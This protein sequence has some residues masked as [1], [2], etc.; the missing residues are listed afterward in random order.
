MQRTTTSTLVLAALIFL[1]S[2]NRARATIGLSGAVLVNTPVYTIVIGVP[3]LSAGGLFISP[4]GKGHAST[5]LTIWTRD[6]LTSLEESEML[7]F[8]TSSGGVV[9]LSIQGVNARSECDVE[10]YSGGTTTVRNSG[11]PGFLVILESDDA[12]SV[13]LGTGSRNALSSGIPTS[14]ELGGEWGWLPFG[15]ENLKGSL[16]GADTLAKKKTVERDAG[17]PSASILTG[18]QIPHG[19]RQNDLLLS[20]VVN[21]A[22]GNVQIAN[23]LDHKGTITLAITV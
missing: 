10:I 15:E 11:V 2:E 4:Q 21:R 23:V 22:A 20:S 1:G 16:L 17:S 19:K 12:A 6:D 9:V 8:T 5:G 13:D 3:D 18:T 14:E 7:L